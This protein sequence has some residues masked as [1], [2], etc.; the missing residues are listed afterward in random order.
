[1]RTLLSIVTIL[2]TAS[3]ANAQLGGVTGTVQDTT[4][5]QSEELG[6]ESASRVDSRLQ[7][8]APT[9]RIEQMRQQRVLRE[10]R[11]AAREAR[12]AAERENA[13]PQLAN[14]VQSR[15]DFTAQLEDA[16]SAAT[17]SESFVSANAERIGAETQTQVATAA[18]DRVDAAAQTETR[19]FSE[20]QAPDAGTAV[21]HIMSDTE[22]DA[23]E[24]RA[25]AGQDIVRAAVEARVPLAEI[26]VGALQAGVTVDT[27]QSV[28][29][30]SGTRT[31][32]T[33]PAYSN[34]RTVIVRDRGTNT[35]MVPATRTSQVAPRNA[36]A[37]T[38]DRAAR[39]VAAQAGLIEMNRVS[40]NAFPI[41]CALLL[42]AALLMAA[43]LFTRRRR[44]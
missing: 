44:V 33:Q 37:S 36:P 27:P 15:T 32:Y 1:M 20:P 31:V 42:I 2:A 23:I 40:H 22:R 10:A 11:R 26:E 4:R 21:S 19:I 5:V 8:T 24:T 41:S 43:R 9:S 6:L 28:T 12:D 34:T 13:T 39:P 17:T 16:A 18:A 7:A 30:G 14:D 35:A 38:P 29:V 25:E 3:V